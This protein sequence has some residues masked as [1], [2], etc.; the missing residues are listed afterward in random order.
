MHLIITKF[1]KTRV[2]ALVLAVGENRLRA[3][4]AGH[5]DVVEF[6]RVYGQWA[7]DLGEVEIEAMTADNRFDL[8]RFH[9]DLFPN[10][11]GAE[12]ERVVLV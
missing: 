5:K 7:S 2:E 6:R 3:V 1:N 12:L 9:A 10:E 4:V 8:T 11:R